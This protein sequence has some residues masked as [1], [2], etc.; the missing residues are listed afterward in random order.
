MTYPKFIISSKGYLR[1]GE[2]RLHKDLLKGNE[3]CYGGGFFEFD[4]VSN[5][6]LLR[7]ASYDFGRPRWEWID[8]LKV[9]LIY[10]DLCIV[11]LSEDGTPDFC[12]NEEMKIEYVT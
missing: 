9:P 3:S 1:L 10:R 8:V 5:R 12:L 6:L 11:Y 7:G 2:V 4:Y